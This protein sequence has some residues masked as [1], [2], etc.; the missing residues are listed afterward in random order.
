MTRD[1]TT[2]VVVDGGCS[3]QRHRTV[4][5]L[6][7]RAAD[8]LAVSLLLLAEPDHPALPRG[9]WAVLRDFLR[10]GM[11]H[12]TG[13]GAV[14]IRPDT[15]HTGVLLDLHHAG[16]VSTVTVP[17]PTLVDFLDATEAIVPAG[18]ERSDAALDALIERL[19]HQT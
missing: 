9:R 4:L 2:E 7:W 8:P 13:D 12:A 10:Y 15:G 16:R 19:L 6:Q 3:G 17:R 5:R 14:R 1:V 18:E 11:D